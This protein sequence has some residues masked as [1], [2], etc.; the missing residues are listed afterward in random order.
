MIVKLQDIGKI[1]F[2]DE[3]G[4]I[5]GQPISH[6]IPLVVILG[7]ALFAKANFR[8]VR[9]SPGELRGWIDMESIGE[10]FHE[11]VEGRQARPLGGNEF[12]HGRRR[13]R[14]CGGRGEERPCIQPR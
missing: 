13:R 10:G 14:A 5:C 12:S 4:I 6:I 1:F 8:L 2:A 7:F 11:G 9:G 3:F